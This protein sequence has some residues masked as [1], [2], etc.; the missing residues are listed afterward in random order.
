MPALGR[1]ARGARLLLVA[2]ALLVSGVAARVAPQFERINLPLLDG[3]TLPAWWLP[4]VT[5]TMPAPAVVALHGCGGL[6]ARDRR[7][8]QRFRDAFARLHDAGYAVL[9]P[10]SFASRGAVNLCRTPFAARRVHVSGR[11]RDARAALAWL[12]AQPSVDPARLGVLGWSN[13]GSTALTLLRWRDDHPEAD[14]PKLAG[15]AV[16]YP[17]C[18]ALE[19]RGARLE[20]VPLLML[21][22]ARDDWTPPQPCIALAQRLQ[23]AADPIALHVYPDS[24]HGFDGRAPVR[25]LA[26][27]PNG[28][29]PRGVHD[30]V[31]PAARRHALAALHAFW[32]RVFA[33]KTAS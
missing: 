17:G 18:N 30:G 4:A 33:T 19:K 3:G 8:T 29:S 31:N 20:P 25:L 21:L 12:A 13:G 14:Q 5:S 15:V 32:Q 1:L 27:V 7:L 24:F 6:Y 9:M 2:L 23:A 11:V 10:D 28:V 22:G 26:D 16:L